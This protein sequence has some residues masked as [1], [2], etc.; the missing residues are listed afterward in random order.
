MVGDIVTGLIRAAV[1]K[2]A[3][4]LEQWLVLHEDHIPG[5]FVEI[6]I[7]DYATHSA[8]CSCG[9]V[10]EVTIVIATATRS[11]VAKPC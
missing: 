4:A 11:L 9:A 5:P 10:Y 2:R 8:R 3:S 1:L 7:G 6:P